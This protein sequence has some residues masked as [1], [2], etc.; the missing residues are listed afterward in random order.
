MNLNKEQ[1]MKFIGYMLVSV[2]IIN[3]VL[4]S[5]NLTHWIVFWGVIIFGAICVYF[6][7]P[8]LKKKN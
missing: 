6:V 3:L 8:W 4:F 7:L 5:F 2:M 1:K